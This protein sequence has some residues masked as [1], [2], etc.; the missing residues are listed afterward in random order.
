MEKPIVYVEHHDIPTYINTLKSY[1]GYQPQKIMAGH[2]LNIKQEDIF[3][4]IEYLEGLLA[5]KEML[6]ASNYARKVH[7]RNL[8][9]VQNIISVY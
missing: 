1:L 3:D 9:A 8:K 5:G 2:T 7:S 4:T 6:F